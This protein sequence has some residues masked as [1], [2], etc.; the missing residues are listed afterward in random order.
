MASYQIPPPTPM[1]LKGDVVENWKEFESAWEDYLIATQLDT[2]LT[3]GDGSP[4]P[5]GRRMVSATLCSI[6]GPE[7]KR[8]LTTLPISEANRKI[9]EEVIKA[10]RDYFIPQRNVLYERFVFNSTTQKPGETIDQFVIRLRQLA[11]SCEFGDLRD[12][13][14]RCLNIS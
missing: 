14:I 8:I 3:N 6:M 11:E 5:D 7:C 13:L 4:N 1:S 2:K 10:L 9:P 12:Q